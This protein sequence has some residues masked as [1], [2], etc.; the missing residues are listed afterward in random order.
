MTPRSTGATP[1]PRRGRR[2]V[3]A[4]F[5]LGVALVIPALLVALLVPGGDTLLPFLVPGAALLRPLTSVMAAWPGALNL[6]LAA[7]LNGMVFGVLAACL[8]WVRSRKGR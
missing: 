5:A 3:A 4:G 7:V 1:T 6:L 2:P 8:A